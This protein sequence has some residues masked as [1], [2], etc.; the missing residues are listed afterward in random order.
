MKKRDR[1]LNK[2]DLNFI[3]LAPDLHE[4]VVNFVFENFNLNLILNPTPTPDLNPYP[5][6]KEYSK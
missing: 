2:P 1:D 4:N 5:N 3:I 6:P